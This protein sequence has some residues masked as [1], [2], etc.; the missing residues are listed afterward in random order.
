MKCS[1][2]SGY[3]V[4]LPSGHPFPIAKFPLLKERLLADGVLA[5]DDILQPEPIDRESL[6]LVHTRE[7]LGKLESSGLSAA[8]QRRLGLPWSEALWLRSRLA[9]G[10]TLLAARTALQT[11]LAGNLAGGTHHA[12]PVLAHRG[13]FE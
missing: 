2:H 3:Q 4:P 11:G 6:Q 1:Y 12:F 7:Y 8:E 10:G 13:I 9:C 5:P